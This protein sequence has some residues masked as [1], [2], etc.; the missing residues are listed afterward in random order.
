MNCTLTDET[1]DHGDNSSKLYFTYG[2]DLPVPDNET[3][4]ISS[5]TMGMRSLIT[6]VFDRPYYCNLK[7][8]V[9]AKN[10]FVDTTRVYS[11]RKYLKYTKTKLYDRAK[12]KCSTYSIVTPFYI[13]ILHNP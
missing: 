5:T 1:V 11:E 8:I 12:R 10:D 13:K 9:H 6:S 2:N 4:I 7:N 3:F